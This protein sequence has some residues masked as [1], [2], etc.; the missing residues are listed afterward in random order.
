MH[1]SAVNSWLFLLPLE[2]SDHMASE[3]TLENN[4]RKVNVVTVDVVKE[5]LQGR[6]VL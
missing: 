6:I 5:V 4:C 2:Q 3:D 1:E